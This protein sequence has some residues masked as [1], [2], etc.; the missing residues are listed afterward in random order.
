MGNNT[1]ILTRSQFAKKT[2]TAKAAVTVNITRKRIFLNKDD[3]I[4]LADPRNKKLYDAWMLNAIKKFGEEGTE[5]LN[6]KTPVKNKPQGTTTYLDDL[7]IVSTE[8]QTLDDQKKQSEIDYKKASTVK[9]NLQSAKLRGENI[10]TSVVESIISELGRSFQR[11][12]T[13]GTKSLMMQLT[14]K[15]KVHPDGVAKLKGDLTKL[16]NKSHADALKIAKK[17]LETVISDIVAVE[18]MRD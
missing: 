8:V 5:P 9:V 1:N 16:I 12:Y 11:A 14:H 6:P 3:N 2:R 13:T 4:D 17:N 18:S 10:P 15:H 7:T